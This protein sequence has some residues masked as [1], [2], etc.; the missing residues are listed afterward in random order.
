MGTVP[1]DAGLTPAQLRSGDA[2]LTGLE[3]Q[4]RPPSPG[5]VAKQ[6]QAESEARRV[7]AAAWVAQW[8]PDLVDPVLGVCDFATA[9]VIS[10]R[11]V[12]PEL[13]GEELAARVRAWRAGWMDRVQ[14]S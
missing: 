14:A 12:Y 6:R 7:A 3:I 11:R 5:E 13:R 1:T 2:W 10:V 8:L 9:S 4:S